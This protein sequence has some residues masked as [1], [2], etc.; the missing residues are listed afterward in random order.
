M[1]TG[2]T[3]DG[4]MVWR[5][6]TQQRYGRDK[7]VQIPVNQI[8]FLSPNPEDLL[9]IGRI[10]CLWHQNHWVPRVLSALIKFFNCK[11]PLRIFISS[12]AKSDKRRPELPCPYRSVSSDSVQARS[13]LLRAA[14]ELNLRSSWSGL[15]LSLRTG[16][17][18]HVD[19][20]L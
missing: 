9:R 11:T 4:P 10:S 19:H 16:V 8:S 1:L 14:E 12:F 2:T 6:E 18:V 5:V 17:S 7:G 20:H 15:G 3:L 13:C